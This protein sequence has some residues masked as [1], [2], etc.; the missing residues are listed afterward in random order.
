MRE[1]VE[2]SS[3]CDAFKLK[4]TITG[5]KV[6]FRMH[7]LGLTWWIVEFYEYV[8]RLSLSWLFEETKSVIECILRQY[9]V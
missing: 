3:V 4:M 2:I 9:E 8:M 7:F 5:Y 1:W 6:S